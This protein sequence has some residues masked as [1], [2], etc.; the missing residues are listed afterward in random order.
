MRS[1]LDRKKKHM[2]LYNK[3]AV[4]YMAGQFDYTLSH[5]KH[6]GLAAQSS[7]AEYQ[8]D[9]LRA[10]QLISEAVGYQAD[11]ANTAIAPFD[12]ASTWAKAHDFSA[13]QDELAAAG[14]LDPG[15]QS[16]IN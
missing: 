15:R 3:S 9:L 8:G 4:A 11:A 7:V 6:Y 10:A 13:A 16:A 5:S 14:Y 12:A 1:A 2:R